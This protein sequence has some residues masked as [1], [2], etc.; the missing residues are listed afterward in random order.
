VDERSYLDVLATA[1]R[2]QGSLQPPVLELPVMI[3]L[4]NETEF[5]RVGRINFVDNR[6]IA[7]TGTVRLRGVFDN[8]AG[9]LKAGLFV[10]IR[11]PV[12]APYDALLIPDEAILSDQERKYVWV[13]NASKEVE[14]RSVKLGQVVRAAHGGNLR[15]IRAPDPGQEGKEGLSGGE[16]IIVAGMQRVRQ[17]TPVD[18]TPTPPP[19]PPDVPLVRLWN[20]VR[21]SSDVLAFL[22][23]PAY[24]RVGPVHR[25]LLGG[26]GGRRQ[27][28]GR[29]VS[30][31]HAAHHP[32]PVHL[33][34][35]R[36]P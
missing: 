26:D 33:S 25:H 9:F 32:G 23:W 14:Y 6:V 19:V 2:S 36:R 22:H 7:T 17:G 31:D 8:A 11:L 28:A 1:T 24:L 35:R 5:D 18:A 27:L 12:A 29:T 4:A 30:A 16:S 21:R 10:R 15:V 34:R 13:V 3:R 20:Q